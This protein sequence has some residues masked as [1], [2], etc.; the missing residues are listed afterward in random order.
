MK[1]QGINEVAELLRQ[2]LVMDHKPEG[3]GW[4]SL[5]DTADVMGVTWQ[6]ARRHLD[7]KVA[8]GVMESRKFRINGRVSL[9]YRVKR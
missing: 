8:E 5:P 1:K 9:C 7:R 4:E 3:E 6:T 2:E